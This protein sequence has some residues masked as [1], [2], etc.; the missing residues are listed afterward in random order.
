MICPKCGCEYRDGF[1]VCADCYIDL[2]EKT[3]EP[4]PVKKEVVYFRPAKLNIPKGVV[5]DV[6]IDLLQSE[7]IQYVIDEP[8][9][10]G[11]SSFDRLS[12]SHDVFVDVSDYKR[13][14]ELIN[15]LE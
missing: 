10:Y 14:V 9:Y 6:V 11:I 7:G 8:H 4:E 13:A 5:R 15:E 2:V 12:Y 1:T 3:V